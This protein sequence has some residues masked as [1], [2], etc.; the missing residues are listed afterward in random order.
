MVIVRR[1]HWVVK[2]LRWFG[3]LLLLYFIWQETGWATAI[4]A[5]LCLVTFELMA[6][7]LAIVLDSIRIIAGLSEESEEVGVDYDGREGRGY[8]PKPPPRRP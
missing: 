2:W 1:M 6:K 4:F 8:Q 7:Y 3:S 5:L